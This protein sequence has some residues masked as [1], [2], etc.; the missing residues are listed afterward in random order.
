MTRAGYSRRASAVAEGLARRFGRSVL[1]D[2][3]HAI[4]N[5]ARRAG[6][7]SQPS[8]PETVGRFLWLVSYRNELI[9]L[10]H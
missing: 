9:R 2:R 1:A 8:D 6:Q 7:L 3:A 5:R 10:S 4:S